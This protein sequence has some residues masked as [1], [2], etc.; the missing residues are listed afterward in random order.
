MSLQQIPGHYIV[1]ASST[2]GGGGGGNALYNPSITATAYASGVIPFTGTQ[3]PLSAYDEVNIATALLTSTASY[4]S[5]S[6]GFAWSAIKNKL[7]AIAVTYSASTTYGQIKP[8]IWSSYN[9]ATPVT[10][11]PTAGVFSSN[12]YE[13]NSFT[14]QGSMSSCI[15]SFVN[16][17]GGTSRLNDSHVLNIG[18]NSYYGDGFT[19]D[20]SAM[21]REL[22]STSLPFPDRPS[23][24]VYTASASAS[25]TEMLVPSGSS[26]RVAINGTTSTQVGGSV[27]TAC[28]AVT[29]QTLQSAKAYFPTGYNAY[30]ELTGYNIGSSTSNI[31]TSQNGLY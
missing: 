23:S 22:T 29:S 18:F 19:L 17:I 6:Y 8:A 13:Y 2:G 7:N 5:Y 25:A 4:V 11:W 21:T 15:S 24:E 26:Y 10:S 9:E 12:N 27:Y 28:E 16:V 20:M 31:Y 14:A 3:I 1:S 30:S